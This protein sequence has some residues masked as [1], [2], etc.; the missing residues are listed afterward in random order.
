[1]N[2]S[3]LFWL[4]ILS[5]VLTPLFRQK[6]LESQRR[7]VLMKLEKKRSSRVITLIHRQETVSF[8][9]IP[10]TR[11]INVDDSEEILRAIRLTPPDLPIDLVLHTASSWT[12]TRCWG[13]WTRSWDRCPRRPS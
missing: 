13:R 11:Y 10:V 8:L 3:W 2:F 7:S 1:M 5:S 12:R 4:F 6:L 9:G